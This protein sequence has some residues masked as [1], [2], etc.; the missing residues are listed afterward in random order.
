GNL[1]RGDLRAADRAG[2]LG[3]AGKRPRVPGEAEII[4]IP[5]MKAV[6]FTRHGGNEVLQYGEQP[7]P[8]PGVGQVRVAIRAAALNHLDIFVRDGIPDV[9]LP[10]IPGGDGSGIVDALGEG[11]EGLTPGDRVL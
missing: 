3:R 9:P 2:G 6:F 8:E 5:A 10:Q 1:D 11:V 4:G 7:T